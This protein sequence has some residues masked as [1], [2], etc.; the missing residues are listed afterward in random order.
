MG[1]LA[2]VAGRCGWYG[3]HDKVSEAMLLWMLLLLFLEI[4]KIQKFHNLKKKKK[5]LCCVG[6]A[7]LRGVLADVVGQFGIGG[8]EDKV[9]GGDVV[10]DVVVV[11]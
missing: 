11:L 8:D 1:V 10:V 3:D 9:A 6:V 7:S 5:N 2:D 4:G